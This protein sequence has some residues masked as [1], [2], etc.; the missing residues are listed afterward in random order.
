MRRSLRYATGSSRCW[1][2]SS[3]IATR[4]SVHRRST[5]RR[6]WPSNWNRQRDVQTK[7][8]LGLRKRL[9]PTEQKRFRRA[10]GLL[11]PNGVLRE[12]TS[13]VHEQARQRRIHSV[14]DEPA[15]ATGVVTLPYR[16]GG[17]HHVR[18]PPRNRAGREHDRVAHGLRAATSAIEHARAWGRRGLH[19]RRSAPHVY[20]R[21]ADAGGRRIAQWCRATRPGA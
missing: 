7:S 17:Q 6:L 21:T 2:P 5:S 18:R 20:C 4:A 15:D 9:E 19:S 10:P 13:R 16:I 14:S 8:P 11:H 1:A 12:C 3:S